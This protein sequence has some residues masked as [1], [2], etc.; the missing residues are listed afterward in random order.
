MLVCVRDGGW[1]GL[2]GGTS[3]KSHGVKDYSSL[4]PPK[5]C[6]T[7]EKTVRSNSTF[8]SSPSFLT[9]FSSSNLSSLHTALSLSLRLC[10][11]FSTASSRKLTRSKNAVAR[12]TSAASREVDRVC[13]ESST[14]NRQSH[15]LIVLFSP[16]A[17]GWLWS[18]SDFACV[19]WQSCLW[20]RGFEP[21]FKVHSSSPTH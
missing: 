5:K 10:Q 11:R 20:K 12:R 21:M 8:L 4:P 14:I 19:R 16:S 18:P 17:V 2:G 13:V 7:R 9:F 6:T 3:A 1:E 15:V